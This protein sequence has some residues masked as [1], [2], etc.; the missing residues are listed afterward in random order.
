ML[1]VQIIFCV[2]VVNGAE[3]VSLFSCG[4]DRLVQT[5]VAKLPDMW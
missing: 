4:I 3:E 5:Q 2:S 1:W